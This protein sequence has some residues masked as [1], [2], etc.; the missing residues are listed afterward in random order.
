VGQG[1]R[2]GTDANVVSV[3]S[4]LANHTVEQKALRRIV[5]LKFATNVHF[6]PRLGLAVVRRFVQKALKQSVV[7]YGA[8]ITCELL[9]VRFAALGTRHAAFRLEGGAEQIALFDVAERAGPA[10]VA[11]AKAVPTA[12][13]N[14]AS[15]RSVA[16]ATAAVAIAVVAA[17][18][19]SANAK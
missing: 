4:A 16:A 3:S 10:A 11:T 15:H 14:P 12:K 13:A 18:A 7:R 5:S 2:D 9:G 17:V 1:S 19:A 6:S 8:R